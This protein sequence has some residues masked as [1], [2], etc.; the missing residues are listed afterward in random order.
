MRLILHEQQSLT[1]VVIPYNRMVLFFY[2]QFRV[3]QLDWWIVGIIDASTLQNSSYPVPYIITNSVS[4]RAISLYCMLIQCCMCCISTSNFSHTH[5]HSSL[6]V[7]HPFHLFHALVTTTWQR[8]KKRRNITF[9]LIHV[10]AWGSIRHRMICR[11][12]GIGKC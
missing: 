3:C 5:H 10:M 1:A 11:H 6:L 9:Q 2:V 7:W 12:L 8:R 4:W